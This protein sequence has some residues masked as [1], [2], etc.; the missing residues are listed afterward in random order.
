MPTIRYAKGPVVSL[1]DRETRSKKRKQLLWGDWLRIGDEI[2]ADWDEITWGRTTYAIR[3]RDHQPDRLCELIFLDVG[4][5]DGCILTTPARADGK[6][7]VMI[8][9]PVSVTTWSAT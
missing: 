2:D 4:Q 6:E 1:Y 8:V 5:G 9:T 3:K 7:R